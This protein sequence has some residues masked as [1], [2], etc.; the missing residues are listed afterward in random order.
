MVLNFDIKKKRKMLRISRNPMSTRWCLLNA[1]KN[2]QRAQVC[3][4]SL[5]RGTNRCSREVKGQRLLLRRFGGAF[6]R[7]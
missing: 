1:G 2:P 3:S 7:K 5:R 4:A 6:E